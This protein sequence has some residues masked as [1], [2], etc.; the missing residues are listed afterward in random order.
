MYSI[1]E[2]CLNFGEKNVQC[3][4][5]VGEKVL[6]GD[7]DKMLCSQKF[8]SLYCL[9]YIHCTVGCTFYNELT[10]LISWVVA[11]SLRQSAVGLGTYS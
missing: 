7:G 2:K 10:I 3:V 5:G 4:G 9:Y 1:F 6:C 8:P 11:F